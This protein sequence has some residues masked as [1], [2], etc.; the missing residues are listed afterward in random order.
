M[1]H[2][3][4]HMPAPLAALRD[5]A[6]L[7]EPGGKLFI[8]IPNVVTSPFDVLIPDHLLHFS[9]AHLKYL[10]G[11][12]GL[13]VSVLRDDLLP[14]EITLLAGRGDRLVQR[15]SPAVTRE[16][17][18]ANVSWLASVLA[19]ARQAAARTPSFGLFGTSISGMWLYGALRE[20][21]SFFID[22]DESRVGNGFEGIPILAPSQ[23]PPGSTVF[24]PL[25]PEVARRVAAR[26]GGSDVRYVEPPAWLQPVTSRS[27]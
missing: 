15:P 4:E 22:E 10:A 19:E 27:L 7:L 17:V 3:L 14:K 13:D 21:V 1:I 5:A 20:K 16:I 11:R 8:E 24:V 6:H 2:A 9:P 25:V 18:K 12:A 26:H 23:A